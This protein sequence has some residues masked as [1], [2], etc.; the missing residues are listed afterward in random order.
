MTAGIH[1]IGP[2]G[3]VA[4]ACPNQ[5]Q[6]HQRNAKGNLIKL[7]PVN[8]T[9]LEGE[10]ANCLQAVTASYFDLDLLHVPNFRLFGRE[11]YL[12]A[13]YF[14]IKSR[15]YKF[16]DIID[17]LPPMDE[18][19]YMAIVSFGDEYDFNHVVIWKDGEIVHD[20]YGK[21]HPNDN[22]IGYYL[23]EKE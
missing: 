20:P 7:T 17:G 8:Q 22:I 19:H 1:Y 18:K 10:H 14:F 21:I 9:I 12:Q 6:L 11:Q 16:V 4:V 5:T 23:L 15:G 13:F 2:S 3:M